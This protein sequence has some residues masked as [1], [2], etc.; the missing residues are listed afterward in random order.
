MKLVIWDRIALKTIRDFPSP[1]RLEVG[2]LLRLL[3]KGELLGMPQ[4]RPIK[5]VDVSAFELRV[6][7]RSGAYRII[8]IL[9]DVD[10]IF[11]PHAFTKKSQK[12]PL[13]E[14]KIAKQRLKRLINEY[15]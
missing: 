10:R 5:T 9:Y 7:D 15:Q 1:V 6:K 13:H 11:I 2:V 4:S 3:Q 8:Y 12:T 14:I